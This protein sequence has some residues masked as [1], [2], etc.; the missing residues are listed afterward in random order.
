MQRILYWTDNGWTIISEEVPE[1]DIDIDIDALSPLD[2]VTMK[3]TEYSDSSVTVRIV[4]DTDKD[5]MC[6][7]DFCLEMQNE[8]T[9]EWRELDEVIDNAV[10]YA[11]GY[12]IQKDSPYETVIDF[13][14]LYGKLELGRYRI[15]KTIMDFRGT[16]DYT[17]YAFTAEF[18][19]EED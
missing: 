18:S 6:G 8:E 17:N 7:S 9:G 3:V 5:I 10:F 1:I 15:V 11:I 19:I 14:R 2:G 12:M 16:G 4:N 13:K